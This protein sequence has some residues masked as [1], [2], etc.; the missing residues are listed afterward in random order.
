MAGTYSGSAVLQHVEEGV[1]APD[2]LPV[3]LYLNEGGTGTVEVYGYG[4]EAEYAGSAVI[5]SVTIK[6]D[7]A[8][9]ACSFIGN[10]SRSGGQIV[11]SGTMI[12]YIFGVHAA[13]Y[14]WAAQK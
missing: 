14:S 5:F 8:T 7:G 10:V 11:I 1:E 6:E 4:G 12:V 3:T 13:T 2:S 9:L